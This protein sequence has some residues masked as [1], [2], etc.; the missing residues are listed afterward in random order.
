MSQIILYLGEN[1]PEI[2]KKYNIHQTVCFCA[3]FDKGQYGLTCIVPESNF[4]KRASKRNK[5]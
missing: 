5:V 4:S 3:I 2:L 1:L